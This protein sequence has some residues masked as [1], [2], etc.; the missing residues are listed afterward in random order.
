MR[1]SSIYYNTGADAG[2]VKKTAIAETDRYLF[3]ELDTSGS[4][5]SNI[6]DYIKRMGKD[7]KAEGKIYYKQFKTT[8]FT[9]QL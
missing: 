3:M 4:V 2:A 6:F 7:I 8:I 5:K 9:D 1:G